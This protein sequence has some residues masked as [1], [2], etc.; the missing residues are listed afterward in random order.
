MSSFDSANKK[1]L[2]TTL[3]PFV[4]NLLLSCAEGHKEDEATAGEEQGD[5]GEQEDQEGREAAQHLHEGGE[6]A[7][8][9]RSVTSPKVL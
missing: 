3:I 5:G 4:D 2:L 1:P 6:E 7:L 8:P 9:R